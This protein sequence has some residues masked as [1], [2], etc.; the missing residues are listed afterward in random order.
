[1][2]STHVEVIFNLPRDEG[3]TPSASKYNAGPVAV[4]AR[5]FFLSSARPSV[6][7]IATNAPMLG[8]P[9]RLPHQSGGSW[10]FQEICQQR[11]T[12]RGQKAFGMELHTV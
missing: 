1:M 9:R 10:N 4:T 7:C 5:R 2:Q 12:F 11:V 6:Y 3:S 8:Q